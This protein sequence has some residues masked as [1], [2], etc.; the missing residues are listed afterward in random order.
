MR[1]LSMIRRRMAAFGRDARG[2]VAVLAAVLMPV[3]IGGLG[4]WVETGYWSHMQ[5]KVQQAADMAAQAASVRLR[6]GDSQAAITATAQRVALV[7]GLSQGGVVTVNLPPVTGARAGAPDAVEV[8]LT[9]THPRYFTAIFAGGRV[10]V[11]GRAV[12]VI[13]GGSTACMLALSPSA[14]SGILVSGSTSVTMQGC[15][16]AANSVSGTA[17]D[18]GNSGATLSAGCIYTVGGAR[19]NANLTLTG[20]AAPRTNSVAARDPYRGVAEP[21]VRG[22]CTNGNVGQPNTTQTLTPTALHPNGMKFLRFCK[23]LDLKGTVRL[24]PGLYIVEGGLSINGGDANSANAASITG[25]G[26]TIY[27]APGSELK[28]NGNVAI[29]LSAPTA[30]PT[31]GILIFGARDTTV[32]ESHVINGTSGSVLQGAVY[33]PTSHVQYSGNSAGTDGCTQ[34]IASTITMTGNSTLR[35]TCDR[36][37]TRDLRASETV[38]LVE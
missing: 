1:I 12:S 3:V 7:S 21:E 23:G 34:I 19:T 5:R 33:A 18:M 29:N 15:D 36:A 28:L 22:T 24:E 38:R 11:A 16:L 2:S 25:A 13:E 20:C 8:I 35:A 6:A 14:T 37:G 31:A 17:Y 27:M 26:V 30:G 9:E 4:L 32:V 10:T